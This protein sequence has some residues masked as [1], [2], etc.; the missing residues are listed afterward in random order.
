MSLRAVDPNYVHPRDAARSAI[1]RREAEE[2]HTRM[3]VLDLTKSREARR[4]QVWPAEGL[5][6]LLSDQYVG[7]IYDGPGR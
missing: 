2:K 1:I 6:R 7:G 4:H 5:Q 3:E